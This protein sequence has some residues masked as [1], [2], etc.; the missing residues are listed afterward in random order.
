LAA[1]VTDTSLHLL[2]NFRNR[3]MLPASTL[4]KKR[5]NSQFYFVKTGSKNTGPDSL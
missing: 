5:I 1:R 3:T 2:P 4:Y